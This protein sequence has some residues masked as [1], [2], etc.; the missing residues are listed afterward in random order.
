MCNRLKARSKQLFSAITSDLAN[1]LIHPQPLT[2]KGDMSHANGGLLKTAF[3][4]FPL[5]LFPLQKAGIFQRRPKPLGNAADKGDF[6][7]LPLMRL[8]P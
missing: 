8:T 7:I 2:V 1:K 4:P 3:E 6:A 5:F